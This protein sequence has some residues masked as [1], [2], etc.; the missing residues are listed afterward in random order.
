MKLVEIFETVPDF[1]N[2]K[3]STYKLSEVLV[4][5]ICAVL[6]GVD[7]CEEI[8]EYG[9]EKEKFLRQFLD[10]E[11][12]T[13]SHDTFNRILVNMETSYFEKCLTDW[14]REIMSGLK[15]YQI[16]IDGK[17]LRATG[18]RGK[19]TAVICIVSAWLVWGNLRYQKRV[20]KRQQFQN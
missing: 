19:K 3:Y 17:V 13:P 14:S 1:R 5:C 16:N 18:Q 2:E 7:D 4:M 15:D 11:N 20:M 6:S 12:G 8:A 9:R 10:L